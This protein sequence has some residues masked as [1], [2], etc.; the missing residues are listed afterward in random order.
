MDTLTHALSGALL[1]RATWNKNKTELSLRQR[2][3]VGFLV[4]AFPD[5]DYILR[6][7]NDNFLV[8]LNYHRGITHSILALPLWAL[9]LSLIFS[10]LL[11]N[12]PDWRSLYLICCLSLGI[13][14][15]G[16]AITSYGTK[17]LA[18]VSD[19]RV[20]LDTT[21]IIDPWFSLIIIIGLVASLTTVAT[22]I[23]A[24]LGMAVLVSYIGMQ[25]W[26]HERAIDIGQQAAEQHWWSDAT[27][28]A[29]PQPVSPFN[30]KIIVEHKQH[31]H[32][33]LVRLFGEPRPAEPEAGFF[34][35][36]AAAYHSPDAV[37]WS[38]DDRYGYDRYEAETIK[39]AWFSENNADF[40]RFTRFPALI[41]S[42]DKEDNC[43]W[44]RDLRFVLPGREQAAFFTYGLCPASTP[45]DYDFKRSD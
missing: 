4:A 21:F 42:A 23:Y 11:R 14:I 28:S 15:A 24:S 29:I 30:W 37:E 36:L 6:L 35:R 10:R 31:Y 43:Y 45:G 1:A 20:W 41:A 40:R 9:L 22:R 13:H 16:D 17:I 18:P 26:A 7:L 3:Q 34:T 2:T 39:R 19:W 5:S 44:F 32:T 25:Y 38:R 33:G 12:S 8:Y 27:V